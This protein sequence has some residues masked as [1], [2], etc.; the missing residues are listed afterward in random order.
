ML[1]LTFVF[2][3]LAAFPTCNKCFDNDDP[4]ADKFDLVLVDKSS[5]ENLIFGPNP[6]YQQD[7]VYL[8]TNL[9]GYTANHSF[10]NNEKI[11]TSLNF[12]V[13]TFFLRLSVLDSDTLIMKY[14]YVDNDCCANERYG[15]LS[16]IIY[17]DSKAE[18]I[19]GVYILF[20]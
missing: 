6:V 11:Q 10:F 4:C 3:L 12:P 1:N 17:N 16:G 7:S 15:K 20:K 8:T 2:L 9:P 19:D 14:D 13:D 5:G 18:K